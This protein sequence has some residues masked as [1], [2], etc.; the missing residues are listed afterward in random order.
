MGMFQRDHLVYL[1][2][3]TLYNQI[4]MENTYIVDVYI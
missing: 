3:P 2:L 1:L 4:Y